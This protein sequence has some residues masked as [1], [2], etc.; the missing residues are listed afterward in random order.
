MNASTRLGLAI[1]TT[2]VTIG[3]GWHEPPSPG[4]VNHRFE[5]PTGVV[6]ALPAGVDPAVAAVATACEAGDLSACN[7]TAFNFA[8]GLGGPSNRWGVAEDDISLQAHA[9]AADHG[10]AHGDDHAAPADEAH[11][12]EHADEHGEDHGEGHGYHAPSFTTLAPNPQM[13]SQLF[14]LT[15][16]NG[17]PT[18]CVALGEMYAAGNGVERDAAVAARYFESACEMGQPSACVA[19]A[20]T[21]GEADAVVRGACNSFY[22]PACDALVTQN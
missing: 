8:Y 10:E 22:T 9:E 13:A 20:H 12:D 4:A 16:A 7:R 1:V 15:C 21:A 18:A 2:A 11:G 3:C 6:A 19:F 14:E 5:V 17:Y